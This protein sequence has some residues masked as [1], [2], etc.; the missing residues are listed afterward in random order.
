MNDF[1][2]RMTPVRSDLAAEHLRGMVDAPRYAAGVSMHVIAPSA[3]LTREARPDAGTETE[4]LCGEDVMAYEPDNGE[5]YAWVQLQRDGYVGYL[6]R[7]ALALG[8]SAPSHRICVPRSFAYPAANLKTPPLC[9]LSLNS[10]V[11]VVDQNGDYVRTREG[12]FIHA[13]HVRQRD[14][15]ETDFVAV[16]ENFLGVPYLWGGKTSLGLDCSG[17]VQ[18]A[19]QAAGLAAP[20]DSDQQEQALGAS[21]PVTPDLTSLQRGDLVFWKGHVGIM[22]DAV[23][24]LHANGH[25]MLVASEPLAEARARILAVSFGPVT[26]IRRLA[27]LG[28]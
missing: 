1:D 16:A 9:T 28:A 21:I 4:A 17:L 20:R 3:R 27:R 13:R 6:S 11:H 19:M 7:E 5:G 10:L 12:W 25:H 14:L 2:R 18:V 26:S 24:L 23:T 15:T 22:R 8:E